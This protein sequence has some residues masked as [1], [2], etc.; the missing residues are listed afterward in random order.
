MAARDTRKVFQV[1]KLV[2][3]L[4]KGK[5]ITDDPSLQG[6]PTLRKD[7]IDLSIVPNSDDPCEQKNFI[8]ERPVWTVRTHQCAT[9]T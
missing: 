1:T 4:T 9:E 2:T 6:G 8:K 7:G 3:N 5:G